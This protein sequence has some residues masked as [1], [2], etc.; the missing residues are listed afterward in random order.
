V[1]ND[2]TIR[3]PDITGPITLDVNAGSAYVVKAITVGGV[4]VTGLPFDPTAYGATVEARIVLTDKVTVIAGTL[5]KDRVDS[6]RAVILIVAD[7]IPPGA[8]VARYARLVQPGADGHFE[9]RGLPPGG[10]A[11]VVVDGIGSR[12]IFEDEVRNRVRQQGRGVSLKE[13]DHVTVDLPVAVW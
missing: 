3:I 12:S 5:P 9:I 4:D 1:R 13:G 10:Y 2:A 6:S 11:A 8:P 7:T